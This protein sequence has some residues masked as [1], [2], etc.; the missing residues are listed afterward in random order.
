MVRV[1][2]LEWTQIWD[3]DDYLLTWNV[4]KSWEKNPDTWV[5]NGNDDDENDNSG[6]TVAGMR[7]LY[8]IFVVPGMLYSLKNFMHTL[9]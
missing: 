2:V 1:E 9:M 3:K 4:N 7:Y 5:Q 8:G 6:M